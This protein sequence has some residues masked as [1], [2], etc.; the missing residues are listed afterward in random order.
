MKYKNVL[1]E[2]IRRISAWNSMIFIGPEN[3][4][5]WH[6]GSHT[7]TRIQITRTLL[8]LR[9]VDNNEFNAIIYLHLWNLNLVFS[10]DV[11]TYFFLNI[12]WNGR[13]V[14]VSEW[15]KLNNK[16]RICVYVRREVFSFHPNIQFWHIVP[17]IDAADS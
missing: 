5:N 4:T 8:I 17:S 11:R 12:H 7:N 1:L 10:V 2:S 9:H 16:I 15:I 6:T 14:Y 13:C 3:T